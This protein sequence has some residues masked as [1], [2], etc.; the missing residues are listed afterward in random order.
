MSCATFRFEA[1]PGD[2]I[3]IKYDRGK[4]FPLF[5]D[6]DIAMMVAPE[7]KDSEIMIKVT[8]KNISS[9]VIGFSDADFSV[10]VSDD[11][12]SW[13]EVPVYT[14]QEYFKKEKAEYTAGAVL[15]LLGA[16]ASAYNAGQGYATTSGNVYGSGRYGSY[17]GSYTSTTRYYDP[18]A[19]QSAN[20][21]SAQM[22]AD[23]A[24][25]GRQWLQVLED[26]LFYSKDLGAG[27][28]YFG[29]VFSEK[30]S[31]RFYRILCR[32]KDIDIVKIEY[33]KVAD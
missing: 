15:M 9:R 21:R 8:V 33:E 26:N 31:G 30:L 23:Y 18:A 7:F 16:A 5:M 20:Q 11:R 13:K 10:F 14:S 24:Q 28:E 29:L 12:L 32:N 6:D 17:S 1:F 19:A 3:Q 4:S 22:V 27:E 25:S 2:N